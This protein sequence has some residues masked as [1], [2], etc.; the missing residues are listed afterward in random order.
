MSVIFF[1]SNNKVGEAWSFQTNSSSADTFSTTTDGLSV[2]WDKGDG[3]SYIRATSGLPS[4]SYTDSGD[5]KT[6]SIRTKKGGIS[7]ITVFSAPL[8]KILGQLD[9]SGWD[10]LGGPNI[11][12]DDFNVS[13][14]P[15]LTGITHTPSNY[16]I[17]S[18]KVNSCDLT[19]NLDL[20]GLN[21]DGLFYA[22]QNPS[23]TS[24]THSEF[25]NGVTTYYAYSCDLTGTHD[26]SSF[27]D[28]GGSFY[29]YLN[30]NLT[31]IIHTASTAT[32]S[33]YRAYN[34]NLTGSLDLSM[35]SGI[36]G[37]FDIYSNPNLTGIVH[38]YSSEVLTAYRVFANNITGNHDLSMFP[39]LG[40]NFNMSSNPNLTGIT[41]TA[42][43]Q[44]FSTYSAPNCNLTGNLDVSML[45]GLAD[46]TVQ[47][48]PNLTSITHT[49]STQDITGGYFV[50]DCNLTGVHDMSML[51]AI[52]S[53]IQ[54]HNNSN[55]TGI[56]FPSVDF[57]GSQLTAYNCDL[58]GTTDV[59][60]DMTPLSG[61][62]TFAMYNN[63]S[64]A[65]IDHAPS[66]EPGNIQLYSCNLTATYDISMLTGRELTIRLYGNSGLT[67]VL[68]PATTGT[69]RN[70]FSS[71]NNEA[72][73]FEGCDLG[74]VDFNPMS[75]ATMDTGSTYGASIELRDN[76][77]T[78]AEVNHILVDFDT[79]TTAAL[80]GWAGVVLDISG[81]NT[82]PDGSSG[83]FD[84][85]TAR[86]NLIANGWTITTS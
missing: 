16:A 55:L 30:P 22:H 6:V 8:K 56:T 47:N 80:S 36:G 68:L 39:N 14:N 26:M 67:N 53:N 66:A 20:S 19:G 27:V 34:C 54:I 1:N 24:I 51:T 52:S 5:T 28:L 57:G 21:F 23:L 10:S 59:H 79:I 82:A 63:T 42:S 18:Y 74:Y 70:T 45:S 29:I 3:S 37:S 44:V 75:G 25:S 9:M 85:I 2:L 84:G 11:F 40:G 43:T 12:V 61:I 4:F 73:N 31:Q 35:L 69:F 15:Q 60:F 38:T 32:F 65:Y 48:N 50:D 58:V 46:F 78:A 49:T 86:D 72:I 33:L 13:N 81:T 41:H 77:M 17:S 62:G 83:G 7:Q 71:G 64:L 76:S